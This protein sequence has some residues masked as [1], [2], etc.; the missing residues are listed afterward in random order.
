MSTW[1]NKIKSIVVGI[2]DASFYP[3]LSDSPWT[4]ETDNILPV[5]S[6]KKK[7]MVPF[8]DND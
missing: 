2:W 5:W 1:V 3:W 4:K 6:N 8:K 7:S